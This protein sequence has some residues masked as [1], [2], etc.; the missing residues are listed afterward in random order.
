MILSGFK[1]FDY[2]DVKGLEG[3]IRPGSRQA[4]P[5]G[6]ALKGQSHRG[7]AYHCVSR[8]SSCIHTQLLLA[9]LG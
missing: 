1:S 8:S 2:L 3:D 6:P 9:V 5:G 4:R 7:L